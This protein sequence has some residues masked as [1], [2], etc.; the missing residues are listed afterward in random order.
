MLANSRARAFDRKV[1]DALRIPGFD[2]VVHGQRG[3]HG[4]GD[5]KASLVGLKAPSPSPSSRWS[6][7]TVSATTWSSSPG[8]AR[9][10]R[11]EVIVSAGR[12][13][14]G[15]PGRRHLVV[16]PPT[17]PRPTACPH[18]GPG[19]RAG[20]A[21]GRRRLPPH[22][23]LA[24]RS[25]RPPRRATN[26]R[27]AEPLLADRG[28]VSAVDHVEENQRVIAYPRDSDPGRRRAR[29]RAAVTSNGH[30]RTPRPRRAPLP[31][32]HDRAPRPHRRGPD[33][34]PPR[35]R[36]W[37]R[38]R[39]CCCAASSSTSPPPTPHRPAGSNSAC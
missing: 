4:G 20:H 30:S 1:T 14:G 39:S 13:A 12:R 10:A 35:R 36:P 34:R 11:G 37:R 33:A 18:L 23:R 32:R 9:P 8:G 25:G 27:P 17:G 3:R 38:S 16:R 15:P 21:V 26:G 29:R 2:T 7:G 31:S 22:R 6:S 28:T 24:T 5:P 19:R